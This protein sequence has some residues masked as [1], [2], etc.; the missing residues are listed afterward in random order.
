MRTKSKLVRGHSLSK[1]IHIGLSLLLVLS[2]L[3][4]ISQ[5]L[6]IVQASPAETGTPGGV[7]KNMKLWLNADL[8]NITAAANNEISRWEDS[9]A[10]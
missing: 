2:V 4:L 7:N 1:S 5:P 6:Q 3:P 8:S 9:S 10:R